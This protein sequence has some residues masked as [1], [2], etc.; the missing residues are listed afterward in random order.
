MEIIKKFISFGENLIMIKQIIFTALVF[1]IGGQTFAQN[2]FSNLKKDFFSGDREHFFIRID[3]INQ[4][5]D[6]EIIYNNR[7]EEI[8][9]NIS[10]G[11][12]INKSMIIGLSTINSYVDI[13]EEGTEPI[14]NG[15]LAYGKN[16]FV[17]YNMFS[18]SSEP[19]L[20]DAYLSLIRPLTKVEEHD[21]TEQDLVRIGLGLKYQ[22]FRG[23][24]FVASYNR[25]FNGNVN[26]G[27]R[28]GILNLGIAY[29]L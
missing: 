18:K 10:I 11:Y 9:Q 15:K 22:V 13:R 8:R 14:P 27:S 7:G 19:L 24:Q 21:Y 6:S 25:L 16:I 2:I 20:R 28:K 29:S 5:D 4:E 17:E 3:L 1:L 12:Y 23:I 26:E